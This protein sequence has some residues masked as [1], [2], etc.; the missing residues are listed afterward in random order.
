MIRLIILAIFLVI[1]LIVSLP[2]MLVELIIQQFKMNLR[3][4]ICLKWV[5]FGFWIVMKISG[6]KTEVKGLENIPD[7]TSVLFA[8]NHKSYFDIVTTY[9]YMKRPTGYIAKA[10][11][12][13]IPLL[14][15]IMYFV[16][17]LF[18]DRE[19]P[20]KGLKTIQK[21]TDYLQNGVSMFICP[22]GTRSKTNEMLPFKEGSLKMAIKAKK[23]IVPV[24]IINSAAIFE[25]HFPKIKPG[26]VKIIFGKPIETKDLS[27]PEQRELTSHVQECVAKLLDENK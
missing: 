15:W 26:T 4:V 5:Q 22:E 25:E 16:N 6:V 20:R 21:G 13:K 1:Y 23:P 24:G 11:M 12:K 18:L 14:S 27:R 9:Q 10:E 19:N 17:C 2:F 7:D 8:S 3:S